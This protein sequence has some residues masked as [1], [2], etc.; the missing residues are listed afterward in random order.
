MTWNSQ[1][2]SSISALNSNG[3]LKLVYDIASTCYNKKQL[4]FFKSCPKSKQPRTNIN[5]LGYFCKKLAICHQ[6]FPKIDQSGHTDTDI[7]R[8]AHDLM[9]ISFALVFTN[10]NIPMIGIFNFI[11]QYNSIITTNRTGFSIWNTLDL[12]SYNSRFGFK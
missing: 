7:G 8:Y 10:K 11:L 12:L 6:E 4:N 3:T 5:N 2:E 1:S 9:I